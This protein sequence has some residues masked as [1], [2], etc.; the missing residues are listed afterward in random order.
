MKKKI[1]S[2]FFKRIS[3]FCSDKWEKYNSLPKKT[4]NIISVWFVVLL[5]ILVLII[6]CNINN[7]G[8]S[9]YTKIETKM[10]KAALEYAEEKE[11]HGISSQKIRIDLEELIDTGK[12]NKL[13]DD[14]CV[15]YVLV[16]NNKDNKTKANAYLSCKSY[17][18]DG[19]KLK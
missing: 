18:T 19:F 1:K 15:G 2:G 14:T 11:L 5:L 12:L 3:K 13:K 10:E 7:N 9:T 4:R 17:I 16:F 8:I 6:I